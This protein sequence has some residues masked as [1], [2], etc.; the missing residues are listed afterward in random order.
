M[1][2]LVPSKEFD[3]DRYL[4]AGILKDVLAACG[5]LPP[6]SVIAVH[7]WPGSGKTP[8]AIWLA[9]HSGLRVI[10]L[11]EIRGP[12][13]TGFDEEDARRRIA[14]ARDAGS[15]IVEGVCAAR[16][17]TPAILVRMGHWSGQRLTS[18]LMAFIG[19]Y[20]ARTYRGAIATF[21]ATDS[22]SNCG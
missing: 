8:T 13:G 14:A 7:G 22:K 6:G 21:E 3:P 15:V 4:P 18:R 11:D 2:T 16:V 19:D 10:H 9:E 20:D 12:D 17:C 5:D 1:L